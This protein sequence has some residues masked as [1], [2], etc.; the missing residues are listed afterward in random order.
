MILRALSPVVFGLLLTLGGACA[1]PQGSTGL[2]D[3][4]TLTLSVVGTNDLHGAIVSADGVGGLALFAGY[5]NNLRQARDHEG[6]AVILVDAGDMWQGTMESNLTEGHVVVEAYNAMGYDAAAVGNH[7]FD[8]GPV[9]PAATPQQDTDDP[10]G[11]LKA[12]AS[13]ARFPFLAANIIEAATGEPVAWPNT[14]PSVLIERSGI[15]VG[16]VGVT[17]ISTFSATIAANTRGLSLAPLSASIETE[18][19]R[20]RALGA[21]VILVAAHAGGSCRDLENPRDLGSCEHPSEIFDVANDLPAGAVDAIVAGHTHAAIAHEVNGIA[22]V[23]SYSRGRAFSRIDF[24]LDRH[25]GRILERQLFLP[26][27]ICAFVD[28]LTG[29]CPRQPQDSREQ[30]TY[31]GAVVNDDPGI[32]ALVRKAVAE[33]DVLKNT[34]LGVV[35]ETDIPIDGEVES[36][37]GNLFTDALLAAVD[38]ADVAI[39]N[40]FGGL[41]AILPRGPVTYGRLFEVFPF[42]NK[43][44]VLRI[45]AA[46]LRRVFTTELQRSRRV[47][48]I[49]GLRVLASCQGSR[50]AVTMLR[51]TG[52]EVTDTEPLVVA[53]TDFLAT[54]ALFR[55][56]TPASGFMVAPDIPR[57]RDLVAEQISR[58]G[59]QL[60][61]DDLVDRHQPRWPPSSSLPFRCSAR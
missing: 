55:P 23:E 42:D 60:R 54:G 21:A 45:A 5:L 27:D 13:D 37:L 38:Y 19:A 29:R 20:L 36:P 24:V 15:K 12:R 2:I 17:T 1:T 52:V 22:I 30:A 43:L 9:G 49:A 32:D 7:E 31:A 56:I 51:P 61:A 6:G 35:A 33:T 26:E 3:S 11:A 28:P 47:L 41:R 25:T 16:V 10:L 50:L 48:G 44:A 57:V 18:A 34:S 4:S 8:F 14:R 39:N 59:G 40:T 53:T 58:R 46:E